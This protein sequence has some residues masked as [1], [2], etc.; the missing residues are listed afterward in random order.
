[1][2]QLNDANASTSMEVL[3]LFPRYL[4]KGT[5]E[6]RLLEALQQLARQVLDNPGVT[7]DASAKLAGQLALQRELGPQYPA[8]A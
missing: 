5:L 6:P 8:V 7:P 3:S 4:L 2:A 1:M